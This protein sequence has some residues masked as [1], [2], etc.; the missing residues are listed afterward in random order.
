MTPTDRVPQSLFNPQTVS[1]AQANKNNGQSVERGHPQLRPEQMRRVVTPEAET[2][3]PCQSHLLKLCRDVQRHATSAT[4]TAKR[5]E[6][7]LTCVHGLVPRRGGSVERLKIL[8]R[9]SLNQT[10]AF[11]LGLW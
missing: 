5:T 7:S 1:R 11:V 4:P 2:V 3:C 6:W 8:V 9:E 10:W